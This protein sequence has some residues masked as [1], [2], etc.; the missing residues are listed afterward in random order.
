MIDK[1]R[2]IEISQMG[3]E[4]IVNTV[5]SEEERFYIQRQRQMIGN[6]SEDEKKKRRRKFL[7]DAPEWFKKNIKEG[8]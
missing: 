1:K 7:E 4:E 2:I 3:K 8:D 5:F 6:I